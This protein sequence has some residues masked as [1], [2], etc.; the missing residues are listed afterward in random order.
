MPSFPACIS[1]VCRL[2]AQTKE[3][4]ILCLS[5]S[6]SA[7]HLRGGA[8]RRCVAGDADGSVSGRRV[9]QERGVGTHRVMSPQP[10]DDGGPLVAAGP[11]LASWPIHHIHAATTLTIAS[12]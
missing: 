9:A 2:H 1:C 7:T 12:G 11:Q 4:E 6:D 8:S 3:L 5:I 10:L